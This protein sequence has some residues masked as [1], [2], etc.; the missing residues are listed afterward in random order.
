[1]NR[2]V[3][4]GVPSCY[5]LRVLLRHL[6][7]KSCYLDLPRRTR[8]R[9]LRLFALQ[10]IAKWCAL[11]PTCL[12]LSEVSWKLSFRDVI[13]GSAVCNWTLSCASRHS[14]CC[15]IRSCWTSASCENLRQLKMCECRRTWLFTNL[16]FIFPVYRRTWCSCNIWFFDHFELLVLRPN[17]LWHSSCSSVRPSYQFWRPWNLLHHNNFVISLIAWLTASYSFFIVILRFWIAD[18]GRITHNKRLFPWL[19]V[20]CVPFL[21]KFCFWCSTPEIPLSRSCFHILLVHTVRL[22]WI[23]LP[24]RFHWHGRRI[25]NFQG[26]AKL[27]WRYQ[28]KCWKWVLITHLER[29]PPSGI[30]VA[31][32]VLISKFLRVIECVLGLMTCEK[33]SVIYNHKNHGML[34]VPSVPWV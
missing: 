17:D 15:A 2:W 31:W 6:L 4:Q 11:I 12:W 27:I 24:G 5:P 20:L 21:E 33:V 29:V 25:R 30:G 28:G 10:R 3:M 18:V 1:M 8:C 23:L 16:I 13:L 14:K 34:E 7:G 32:Q 19:Q 22:H 9:F 26:Y